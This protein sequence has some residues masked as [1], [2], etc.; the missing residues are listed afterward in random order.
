[1]RG[2]RTSRSRPFCEVHAKNVGL[3]TEEMEER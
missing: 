2:I 1:M 3:K